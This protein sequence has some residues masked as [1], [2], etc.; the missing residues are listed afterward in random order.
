[1]QRLTSWS[2]IVAAASVLGLGCGD[3]GG[4][5][6]IETGPDG[7][8]SV[9]A[10]GGGADA[11]SRDAGSGPTQTMVPGGSI[12]DSG[13]GTS[14]ASGGAI[15]GSPTGATGKDAGADATSASATEDSGATQGP[16]SEDAGAG[17]VGANG[18][19]ADC[20][21]RAT[22]APQASDLDANGPYKV[23]NFTLPGGQNF[24]GATVYYPSD[25]DPPFA[26]AAFCPPYTATQIA[27]AAWGPFFA[28]HGIV[29]ATMDSVTVGDFPPHRAQ[30]LEELMGILKGLQTNADSPLMGKL[31]PDRGG[32][33]GWSM[34]GG[35]V[36]IASGKHPEWKSAVTLAG[37]NITATGWQASAEMSSVPTLMLNGGTD[38]TI[39]GG[40]NQT[41]NAYAAIPDST[42]KLMYIMSD[43]GHFDWGSPAAEGN[44]A[45]RY[46]MA[47][48]KTFLEG[49]ERYRPFL[50][51]K[52]PNAQVWETNLQ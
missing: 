21:C 42:P 26:Y 18:C 7:G 49:D 3:G 20:I 52:G 5:A 25:A 19:C 31:D 8:E 44:A 37:H 15:T 28:S 14:G 47:W 29:L 10:G 38:Q 17:S 11:A 27:F 34:G 45:G 1:M 16:P 30:G 4:P 24:G 50:L 41:Q 43:L 36:W 35:G 46:V 33:L 22:S 23:E 48:E 2:L 32:V 40:L 9:Q 39:L 51:E 13:P 6:P 12:P